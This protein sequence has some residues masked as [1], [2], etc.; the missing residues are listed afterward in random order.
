MRPSVWT[1]ARSI[2]LIARHVH[3]FLKRAGRSVLSH[4]HPHGRAKGGGDQGRRGSPFCHSVSKPVVRVEAVFVVSGQ[5]CP[6]IL[7]NVK[8]LSSDSFCN[9]AAVHWGVPDGVKGGVCTV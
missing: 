1:L 7:L 5:S 3:R 4:A 2:G 9:C 6:P 8:W